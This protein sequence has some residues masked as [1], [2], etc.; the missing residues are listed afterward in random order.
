MLRPVPDLWDQNI[1]KVS[2]VGRV[3]IE[4]W[5]GGEGV[6]AQVGRHEGGLCGRVVWLVVETS[7][8]SVA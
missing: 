1:L 5:D 2:S 7:A 4:R 8:H 6:C 3:P